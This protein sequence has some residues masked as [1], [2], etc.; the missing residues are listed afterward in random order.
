MAVIDD[1]WTKIVETNEHE[2]ENC[3]RRPCELKR[4]TRGIG[5]KDKCGLGLMLS[6]IK[7]FKECKV[8]LGNKTDPYIRKIDP[9]KYLFATRRGIKILIACRKEKGHSGEYEEHNLKGSGLIEIPEK[10][11]GVVREQSNYYL[12]GDI[13]RFN[14]TIIETEDIIQ[15]EETPDWMGKDV[16]ITQSEPEKLER[17]IGWSV[18]ESALPVYVKWLKW[19]PLIAIIIG[20]MLAM[21]II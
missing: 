1:E 5:A 19:R 18:I 6:K 14:L 12:N 17:N 3:L 8:H 10:C 16:H 11:K 15:D 20:I 21:I 7:I 2:M 4:I 9:G 13:T